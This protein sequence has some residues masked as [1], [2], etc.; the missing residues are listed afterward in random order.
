MRPL[1]YLLLVFALAGGSAFAAGSATTGQYRNLF[2]E[3][4]GKTDAEIEARVQGAWNQLFTGD[5]DSE[6]LYYPVAGGMAYVPDINNHDVRSEGLS[7]GMMIAVQMDQRA[8][9][10]DVCANRKVFER[11]GPACSRDPALLRAS[12][13]IDNDDAASL[14]WLTRSG[15]HGTPQ[16]GPGN[17]LSTQRGAGARRDEHRARQNH[18]TLPQLHHDLPLVAELYAHA[19]PPA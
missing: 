7:Y 10:D 3:Y 13:T 12:T 5:P 2:K 4:L 18:E 14:N 15:A 19:A 11:E 8:H 1:P 16:R 9:F 6:A 17:P